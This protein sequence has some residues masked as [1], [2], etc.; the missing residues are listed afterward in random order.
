[1]KLSKIFNIVICQGRADQVFADAES[2]YFART[3]T[4]LSLL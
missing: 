3:N 4:T 2:Q 1:M